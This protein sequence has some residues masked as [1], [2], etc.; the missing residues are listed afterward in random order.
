LN[1]PRLP[2]RCASYRVRNAGTVSDGY[3]LFSYIVTELPD[4]GGFIKGAGVVLVWPLI[5]MLPLMNKMSWAT[6][7]R[8]K[9]VR[10]DYGLKIKLNVAIGVARIILSVDH[11]FQ[12]R[13]RHAIRIWPKIEMDELILLST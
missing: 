7:A 1:L 10:C 6:F 9:N 8:G 13:A 4:D 12:S 11:V 2:I 3:F 5:V